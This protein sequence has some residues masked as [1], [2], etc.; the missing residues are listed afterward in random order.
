MPLPW[1]EI[2]DKAIAF[3]REWKDAGRERAEAQTF[4]NEFFEVFGIHRRRVAVFEKQVDLSRAK[5]KLKG[6]RIFCPPAEL[7]SMPEAMKR[8][9]FLFELYRRYTS[10]LPK[11]E[12]KGSRKPKPDI[13]RR[14][15]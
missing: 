3:S 2:R 13:W 1:T 8:V 4:W 15:L 7:R 10:L 14:R 5:R 11:E 9:A 12:P 6:G